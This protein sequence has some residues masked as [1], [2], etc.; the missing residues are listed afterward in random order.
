MIAYFSNQFIDARIISSLRNHRELVAADAKDRAVREGIANDF[1][2]A[3][4]ILIAR[5][6]SGGIV[7]LFQIVYVQHDDRE[8]RLIPL[9][10]QAV[11]LRLRL[12][13]GVPV[14]HA[15]QRVD[16]RLFLRVRQVSPVFL[17]PAHLRVDVVDSDDQAAAL[18]LIGHSG[19]ELD[20]NGLSVYNEAITQGKD[21]AAL[22]FGHNVFPGENRKEEVHVLRINIAAARFPGRFKEVFAFLRL[23]EA[24]LVAFRS[25]EL[26]IAFR[27]GLHGIHGDEIS[28]KRVNAVIRLAFILHPF[29]RDALLHQFVD[30]RDAND[31]D[32]VIVLHARD[33][34]MHIEPNAVLH[35]AIGHLKHAGPRQGF[36]QVPAIHGLDKRL[37]VIRMD[38]HLYFP[39]AAFKEIRAAA[40]HREHAAVFVGMIFNVLVG[41]QIHVEQFHIAAGQRHRDVRENR[42]AV[43]D[44][45]EKQQ[46]DAADHHRLVEMA[47]AIK[48]V[49]KGRGHAA[50]HTANQN[51]ALR[52]PSLVKPPPDHD[53]DLQ[54]IEESHNENK[55][56]K[57]AADKIVILIV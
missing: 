8:R 10:D 35:P 4:E 43:M 22:Y 15:R 12:Q 7:D 49:H 44:V 23:A 51:Q 1:A 19:L 25:A 14:F 17:F 56:A 30:V 57:R 40:R 38:E 27:P 47:P 46:E 5:L 50:D 52:T 20:V 11:H 55:I 54:H 6:M 42:A 2:G 13:I 21:A 3:A 34:H 39:P 41:V 32:P 26:M 24:L 28:G 37:V 18:A 53:Q 29:L 36:R 9:R 45:K 16:F 33:L 31:D 48:R